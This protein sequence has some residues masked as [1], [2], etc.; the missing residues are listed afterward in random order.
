MSNTVS[1]KPELFRW[2]IKRS[3]LTFADLSAKIPQLSAWQSGQKE[4][5]MRQLEEF[6]KR[7]MTPLGYLFLSKPPVEKFAIPDFRTKTDHAPK[8][9]SP[10]LIETLHDM[11]RRQEWMRDYLIEEGHDALA[12][13]GSAKTSDP[14]V[15]VA[16]EIRRVLGLDDDWSEHCANWE[17]ALRKLRDS[18][19]EVG[20][21]VATSGV[22]GLNNRRKLDPDEFRGF[23]LSDS[24]APLVFVNGA[25]TKSAQMF[26][27][28]HELAHVWLGKDG[29]FNLVNTM[30]GDDEA[31]KYCNRVAAEFL[32]PAEAMRANWPE[33]ADSAN[34][35]D[36]LARTFKVSPIVIAR[37]ALDLR[38]I[39]QSRFFAFYRQKQLEWEKNKEKKETSGG[40]FYATQAVRLGRKFSSTVVRA[41]RADKLLYRSAYQ[42]TG[43]S[44]QT[45]DSYA[46]RILRE[47]GA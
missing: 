9:P 40:N 41:V 28:A 24:H 4:P 35:F 39:D 23:V 42:L 36:K 6:A 21:M 7:T 46:T 31:E 2:A 12:F 20:I 8:Q 33:V 22:V 45:F 34:P 1:V 15:K 44:G 32:V 10:N 25:D 18:M 3:G 29:L 13:V 37:R 43:L 11:Q 5:T 16:A 47:P 30:P 17:D 14:I 38:F 26:T 19:D 27:L